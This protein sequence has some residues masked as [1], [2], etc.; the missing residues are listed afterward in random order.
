[1]NAVTPNRSDIV[2]NCGDG[3]DVADTA[4]VTTS[5]NSYV[6]VIGS[7]GIKQ[8]TAVVS[9]S[10]STPCDDTKKKKKPSA[11]HLVAATSLASVNR[12][13]N[14]TPQAVFHWLLNQD[15]KLL[16]KASSDDNATATNIVDDDTAQ[17]SYTSSKQSVFML[18]FK[19][20][21]EPTRQ[22]RYFEENEDH[23][24]SCDA[25]WHTFLPPFAG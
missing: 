9:Q 23:F 15:L 12:K 8:Q 25:L 16:G 24:H 18:R 22:I 1:M 2:N 5:G 6:A 4:T 21:E 13:L 11:A 20:K 10:Q 14:I 7:T 3:N 17:I 19:E